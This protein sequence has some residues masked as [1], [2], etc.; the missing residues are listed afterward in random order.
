QSPSGFLTNQPGTLDTPCKAP[1][2]TCIQT[3][4]RI[5][6][7]TPFVGLARAG[8]KPAVGEGEF[9]CRYGAIDQLGE[10]PQQLL[11]YLLFGQ[12]QMLLAPCAGSVQYPS[13]QAVIAPWLAVVASQSVEGVVLYKAGIQRRLQ[14]RG[15][16]Q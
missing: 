3:Q 13:I 6:Q 9:R 15:K 12:V 14:W 16:A 1:D 10:R 7:R 2:A 8:K 5:G 11:D 4:M